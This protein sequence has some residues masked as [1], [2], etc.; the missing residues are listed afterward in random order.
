M[1]SYQKTKGYT[2]LP[3]QVQLQLSGFFLL[4]I[5]STPVNTYFPKPIAWKIL[6]AIIGVI[7]WSI[8]LSLL[9]VI[10]DK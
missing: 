2:I 6:D 1:H 4:S 5:W 9:Y 10:A 7:M 3:A 8:A